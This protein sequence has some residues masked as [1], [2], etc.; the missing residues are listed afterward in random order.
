MFPDKAGSILYRKKVLM[1][2]TKNMLQRMQRRILC[3]GIVFVD[4]IGW[5]SQ[6]YEKGL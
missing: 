6:Y 5:W 3:C 1:N 2:K 4:E